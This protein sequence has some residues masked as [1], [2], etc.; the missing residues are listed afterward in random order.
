MGKGGVGRSVISATI[1][2]MAADVG[3]RVL[4][5]EINTKERMPSLLGGR[6]PAE[7]KELDRIWQIDERI[8]TVNLEPW[9]AMK[10]YI[11]QVL[12]LRLVYNLVFENKLMRQFLRAVPG[13]QELVFIGKI[14]FHVE[15]DKI[16]KL[17]RFDLVIVDAP[18][19]GHGLALL[20]IAK[21]ILDI[22]PPSP[23]RKAAEKIHDLLTD[24]RQT[25]INLITLPE[26]MPINETIELHSKLT[27]E[28]NF[29]VGSLWVNQWPLST[30]T[31]ELK[32]LFENN[33]KDGLLDP[34]G[35]PLWATG[36]IQTALENKAQ[37]HLDKANDQLTLPTIKIP[38][39]YTSSTKESELISQIIPNYLSSMHNTT[40]KASTVSGG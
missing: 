37:L 34:D 36:Q 40:T 10:E 39:F 14:W 20:R 30:C 3:K 35:W 29:P 32:E 24:P 1:A 28:Y 33:L 31:P 27:A 4:V 9:S 2:R 26:E 16:D 7:I 38:Y 6:K 22:S 21:V 11:V 13:L 17:P 5:C 8:W 15:D 12:R 18:A 23:M 25:A 19:T